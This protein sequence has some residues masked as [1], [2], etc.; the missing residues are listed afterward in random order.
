MSQQKPGV[1]V[2][3]AI[4]IAL[5]WGLLSI[6]ALA[7]DPPSTGQTGTEKN[8]AEEPETDVEGAESTA[9]DEAIPVF[10]EGVAALEAEDM[11]TAL[12]HFLK[13]S[14]IDPDFPEAHIATAAIAMELK[15]FQIAADAAEE[16]LRLQPENPD[17]VGTAYFAE[18]MIGDID[19]LIP[20]ARRLADVSPELVSNEMLQHAQVLFD[21]DEL[22]GSRALLEVILER[23][24][25]LAPAYFQLGLTC[26]MLGDVECAKQALR[27]FLEVAPDDP[28]AAIAQSLLDYL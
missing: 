6:P 20:S 2:G 11:P 28:D 13:A 19:R 26:N 22:A 27:K 10:N 4:C 14:E 12:E 18:L 23:E 25:E 21:D 7:E 16:I 5:I 3:I 17:A 9:R 8:S 1:N 24:P 15:N